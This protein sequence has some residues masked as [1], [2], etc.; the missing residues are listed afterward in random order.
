MYSTYNKS[1]LNNISFAKEYFENILF[2][3]QRA[4]YAWAELTYQ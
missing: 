2:D 1:A 4:S 3:I